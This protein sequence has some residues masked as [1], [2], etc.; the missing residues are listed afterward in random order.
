LCSPLLPT[1]LCRFTDCN[2]I[3]N[4]LLQKVLI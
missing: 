2:R 4:L 1:P 3:C